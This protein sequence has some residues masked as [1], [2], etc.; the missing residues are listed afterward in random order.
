[1]NKYSL[2]FQSH[3][4]IHKISPKCSLLLGSLR[5]SFEAS[6]CHKKNP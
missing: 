2:I 6:Q 3:L 4:S 1:M 5:F